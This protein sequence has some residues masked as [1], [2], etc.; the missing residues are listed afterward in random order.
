MGSMNRRRFLS[1]AGQA[2]ALLT[3]PR[4]LAY[5]GE[6]LVRG[7]VLGS[8]PGYAPPGARLTNRFTSRYGL[9]HPFVGAG[10]GFVATAPLAAAVTNAG[11]LGVIGC[12]PETP[13]RLH[14]HLQEAR[15]RTSGPLGVDLLVAQGAAGP[16]STDLH[17]DVCIQ[18]QVSVVVFFWN[19]PPQVWVDRLQAAGIAV[20][21]QV[22]SVQEALAAEALGVEVIIAQGSGAGGHNRSTASTLALLQSVRGAV[23][24]STLVLAAG[25]IATGMDVANALR[26][27]ADGVW[28]GTRLVASVEAY[29]HDT[30]KQRLL[31][32][33]SPNDTVRTTLFGPEWPGQPMRVLR[34]RVVNQW[35]GN[36]AQVPF[37]APPPAVIGTTLFRGMPYTMP[38]FSAVVP[39]PDTQ[40]DFEEMALLAGEGVGKITSIQ[41]AG[42]IVA[43]M[44]ADAEALF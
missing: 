6:L 20:W 11:G 16:F 32:A 3:A 17:I 19:L 12:G 24:P 10:M 2:A 35:A 21:M 31:Q 27:G 13:E 42:Q 23:D 41:P 30:Y 44:M 18:N 5:P 25:G 22:G 37:P 38:K 39:T 26:A 43:Q 14:W 29:A 34:N 1:L 7:G 40:G 4:A 9:T 33:T 8:N 36:E 28:V 15:A